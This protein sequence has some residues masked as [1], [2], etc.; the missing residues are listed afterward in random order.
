M[1]RLPELTKADFLALISRILASYDV[2][3]WASDDG[4][5]IFSAISRVAAKVLGRIAAGFNAGYILHATGPEYAAATVTVT[6]T[7]GTTEAVTVEDGQVICETP[8]GVQYLLTDALIVG[9][10]A[11]A[12]TTRTVGV[13]AV[14]PGS[15]G[16][17]EAEF[18][19]EWGLPGGVSPADHIVWGAGVTATAKT[20]LLD[21]ID[22]GTITIAG[23]TDATGG[24]LGTLDLLAAER[25]LP[26]AAG[27]ID[28]ALRKRIRQWS[29]VVTPTAIL[30]A[31]NEVLR[32][33]GVTATMWEPWDSWFV[34]GDSDQ[35]AI[36]DPDHP[37]SRHAHFRIEVPNLGLDVDGFTVGA[38]DAGVIGES[39]IGT[40]DTVT[41]GIIGGLQQQLDRIKAGGV[42]AV[43]VEMP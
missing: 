28:A 22:A 10:G 15:E 25:G 41:E 30:D 35:G 2:Q 26:R 20:E 7:L 27:E 24:S 31:V 1:S 13:R 34:I 36:G 33:D 9:A 16:N 38:P 23:N 40:G 3:G 17:V 12:P 21:G 32:P 6:W 4:E 19:S 14:S 8:W 18:I 39:P 42:W 11:G 5:E 43:A 29:K 37:I